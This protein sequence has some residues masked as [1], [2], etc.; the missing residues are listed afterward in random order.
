MQDLEYGV[1]L[2]RGIITFT[3]LNTS[4]TNHTI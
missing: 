3:D 4:S 2:S 1:Y